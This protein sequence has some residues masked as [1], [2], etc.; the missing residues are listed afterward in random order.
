[1]TLDDWLAVYASHIPDHIAQM[2]A[3]YADWQA[4]QG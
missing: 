1:M 3:V 2:Q 4:R